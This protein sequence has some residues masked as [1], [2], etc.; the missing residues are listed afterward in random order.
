MMMS[1]KTTSWEAT[2]W[3]G[4]EMCIQTGKIVYFDDDDDYDYD[5]MIY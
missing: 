4:G 1:G 5:D 3:A 2:F